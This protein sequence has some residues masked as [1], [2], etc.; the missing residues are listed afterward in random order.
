MTERA[1]EAADTAQHAADAA[2]AAAIEH[3]R[4]EQVVGRVD[5]RDTLRAEYTRLQALTEQIGLARTRLGAASDAA[6]LLGPIDQAAAARAADRAAAERLDELAVRI[7]RARTRG[8]GQLPDELHALPLDTVCQTSTLRVDPTSSDG[9]PLPTVQA[10][11]DAVVARLTRLDALRDLAAD[12]ERF[13]NQ[14]DDAAI[15]ATAHR[16]VVE[17][18]Q[19]AIQALVADRSSLEQRLEHARDAQARLAGADGRGRRSHRAAPEPPAASTRP[20]SRSS[21][22]GS[23]TSTP[24]DPCRTVE[25]RSTTC[26]STTST[27]SPQSWPAACRTTRP[28]PCAARSSTRRLPPVPPMP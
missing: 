21:G 17:Q 24:T 4:L 1:A 9:D 25:P 12:A 7:D 3:D 10:A 27:A 11:R 15:A 5:R 16:Q 19:A 20:A 23:A 14:A 6:G 8:A 2:S 18:A 22:S 26:A 28:A 13:T